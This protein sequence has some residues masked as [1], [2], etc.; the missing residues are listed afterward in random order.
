MSDGLFGA[1]S[2]TWRVHGSP[3]VAL[4]GGLRALVIQ[5]LHPLA[6]A[7]VAQHS[8]YRE[9]PLKR[10]QRTAEFV[11]VTTYGSTAE[12]E[13]AA[14]IV[15][16]VHRRVIGVDPI[17]GRPYSAGDPDTALWI[18]CVE[19]HSFM[20]AHRAY[21]GALSP[22]EQDAYYAENAVVAELLG[23]P[24]DLIPRDADAMRA[25]FA[26]QR[27][28]LCVSDAA[29]DAIDFVASPPLTPEL[30]PYWLP[31]RVLARAAIALVPRD[32]RRLI[33]LSPTALGDA[34]CHAQ[35]RA[36]DAALLLPGAGLLL[37]RTLGER[38]RSV[39]V[40]ARAAPR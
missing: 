6:M 21:G 26:A 24:P 5:A 29:R 39:A 7:G 2:V 28:G 30:A 27:P 10:L 36:L 23:V 12:A 22:S 4:V 31:L 33:G 14:A 13:R 25:F 3:A 11:A 8:D 15:R 34:V 32:L 18:H 19:I 37:T 35:V 38:T 9:R 1:D 17:T 16:R 40:A 20:A